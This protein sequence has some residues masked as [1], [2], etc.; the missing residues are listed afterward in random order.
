MV[1]FISTAQVLKLSIAE[2]IQFVGDIWDSIAI[3]PEN[4]PLTEQQQEE[5]DHR[6]EAYH[7]NPQA[8]SPWIQVK[9]K[10]NRRK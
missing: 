5:L 4:V 1:K 10:L 8:G 9:R 7:K 3:V 6:L 2:R